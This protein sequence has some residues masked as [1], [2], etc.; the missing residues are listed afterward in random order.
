M[1]TRSLI[2]AT[3]VWLAGWA[4]AQDTVSPGESDAP[5]IQPR[6]AGI[7][8]VREVLDKQGV[9]YKPF[10]MDTGIKLSMIFANSGDRIVGMDTASCRLDMLSD[11]KGTNLL[12]LTNRLQ[13]P[14]FQ[15]HACGISADGKSAHAE[16]SGNTAPCAGATAVRARG[17]AVFE[18]ASKLETTRSG[19]VATGKGAR[20]AAGAAGEFVVTRWD[21]GGIAGKGISLSLAFA[22]RPA[23][24]QS[25]RFLDAEG[26]EIVSRP[27]GSASESQ[28]E[29]KRT[30]LHYQLGDAPDHC[31]IEVTRWEDLK[32]VEVPFSIRA[33]L[34]G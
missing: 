14:G 24:I 16:I 34:G 18:T 27:A 9:D 26:K 21:T 8:V 30:I 22:G 15:P 12:A 19:L 10:G 3:M 1:I 6:I 31:A 17:V 23:A 2:A 20:F 28:G 11:D 25:L 5:V 29:E 4:S 32:P 13:V 7:A 33:G